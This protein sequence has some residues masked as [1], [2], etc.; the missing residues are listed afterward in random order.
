MQKRVLAIH[1]ISCVGR[2]SLTVALPIL[3]VA[4]CDTS[5]LPTAVL[6][7]HTGG[8]S[9]FTYRDLTT[10]IVPIANHWDSLGLTFSGMY[11]GFLGSVAQIDLVMQLFDKFNRGIVLVDPVMADNGELYSIF[12]SS[13]V[14]GM[15]KLVS[16][17][18][19]IVPNLT[20]ATLLL[21][22]PYIA[23]GYHL[24]YVEGLAVKLCALGAKQVVLTGISLGT[25]Q[26][27]AYCF[28]ASTKTGQYVYNTKVDGHYHGTG[29]IFGS[30]LL[31]ALMN[32]HNLAIS[33]QIA[34][35]YTLACIEQ[36]NIVG[37]EARYGVPFELA[38]GSYMNMLSNK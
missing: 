13:M 19:I 24:D 6:S 34:V 35:D 30:A 33:S 32:G 4:G 11:S 21:D 12:D 23:D 36:Y 10:D 18:D 16:V 2:C 1:D 38:L 25:D 31:G 29:D 8:F 9:G 20:E 17:A 22:E 7:T 27:G 5:V 3:S 14:V 26:L 37:G 28:D 15:R